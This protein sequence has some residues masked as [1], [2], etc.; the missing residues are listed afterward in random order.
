M[1]IRAP[2]HRL[3]AVKRNM[4]GCELCLACSEGKV[5]RCSN[6]RTD[7]H[8]GVMDKTISRRIDFRIVLG[9]LRGVTPH[10]RN[11]SVRKARG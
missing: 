1:R 5:E 11:E 6:L 2:N 8:S 9:I 3:E 10:G 7:G 4:D